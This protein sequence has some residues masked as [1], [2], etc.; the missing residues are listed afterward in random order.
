[1]TIVNYEQAVSIFPTMGRKWFQALT[2]T[3]A[4]ASAGKWPRVA[5]KGTRKCLPLCARRAGGTLSYSLTFIV[6]SLTIFHGREVAMKPFPFLCAVIGLNILQLP[7]LY[8]LSLDRGKLGM[9]PQLCSS[10]LASSWLP[11]LGYGFQRCNRIAFADLRPSL[12]YLCS[13]GPG[14]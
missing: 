3:K 4:V 12:L 11:L 14:E 7:G 6:Q 10:H 1:M 8:K 13:F 9:C 2:G 5:C